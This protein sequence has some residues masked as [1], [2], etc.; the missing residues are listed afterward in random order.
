[1]STTAGICAGLSTIRLYSATSSYSLLEVHLLLVAGAQHAGLLHAG[2]RQH[3]HVV[4]LRVV[5]AVQQVD[6]ARAR[7]SPGRRR[8]C[9]VAFAYAGRHERGGL[10]VV[11]QHEPD[12]VLVPA[13]RLH[14]PVD[15]VAGQAEDGVDPP[16][17]QPLDQRLGRDLSPPL[18]PFRD[19]LARL[20]RAAAVK[21]GRAGHGPCPP[22]ALRGRRLAGTGRKGRAGSRY[23]ARAA[24][25]SAVS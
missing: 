20:S 8:A 2:D 11:H 6:A 19:V 24:E 15:A 7:R 14:D 17:D 22:R 3:R 5:Q 9:P 10:L 23:A 13:Q 1:M 25:P 4:E 18:P 12:P 16:V 21:R